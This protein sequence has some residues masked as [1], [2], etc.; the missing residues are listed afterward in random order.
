[1]KIIVTGA[2]GLLGREIITRKQSGFE[3]VGLSHGELDVTNQKS[4]EY[5]LLGYKPDAIVNCAVVVNVDVCEK[6]S[7]L[8]FAINRDGVANVLTTIKKIGRP[9]TF[10]QISSSEVFGRVKEGE[11]KIE[12]YKED[13]E[14]MPVTNYQK[15]KAEAESIVAEFGR[16]NL[17]VLPH[18]FILRAAWLYGKGRKTFVEGFLKD[19]Q[20]SK[21]LSVIGDQWRSPTWTKYFTDSL[22]ELLTG[23]YQSGIYHGAAEVGRGEATTPQ[24]IEEITK[25]LGPEKVRA[26]TKLIKRDDF[27]KIPRA[28]SNVLLN[29]KLPRLPYWR[30]MLHEYLGTH[31]GF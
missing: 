2:G 13:D 5:A 3:I 14:P 8:C 22:F 28:P 23:K 15:S 20:E 4:I 7:G 31:S 1:M 30:D 10:V 21:E 24:V 11:Y 19:L 25:C 29:T 18:W 17:D 6:D 12:G 27:F 16:R 26:T 9:T